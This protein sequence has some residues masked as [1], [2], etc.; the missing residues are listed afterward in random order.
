MTQPQQSISIRGAREHNLQN[1][2]LEIPRDRLV[3]ITG[4][5]GSGKSSLAFDTIFAEGQRRYLESLSAYARQFMGVME[6]P[7]VDYIDGLSPVIAI[8]QKSVSRNPRSTVGTVTEVYDFLRLL[9]ARVG[10]PHS[11]ASGAALQKQSERE[12][13]ASILNLKG[14]AAPRPSTM[15]IL[16]PVVRGRRGHYR[17]RFVRIEAQ[18][19]R[20]V[21]VD[22]KVR[23][24]KP[25]MAL[26][27][28]RT[29]DIDVV[30]DRLKLTGDITERVRQSV[31]TALQV[32]SGRLVVAIDERKDRVYSTHLYD[33]VT[34]R[35]YGEASPGLFSFNSP[36][37]ACKLCKGLGV[38][39]EFA[40]EM[41]MTHPDHTIK[42][43]I[44][45][46]LARSNH[47]GFLVKVEAMG[48]N[49]GFNLETRVCDLSDK[50]Q[51]VL[52]HGAGDESFDLAPL[53]GTPFP[54]PV[55]F[56]GLHEFIRDRLNKATSKGEERYYRKFL[57]KVECRDCQGTRLGPEPLSYRFAGE[58]IG[59]L[60]RLDVVSLLQFVQ[61]VRLSPRQERIATPIL[62]EVGERL[63]FMIDV[64]VGYLNL[65]RETRSLS[66]GESQ[67][68]RLATQIGT[69]L[70]G[71]LYVLDEPSI[72][73]HPRDNRRL[74][75]SLKQLRDIGNSVLVVEHDREM[76]ESA[77]YVVD[78]G[79]G[80]GER[81]GH[82]VSAGS[83]DELVEQ[84]NGM[85]SL[86]AEYLTGVREIGVPARRRAPQARQLVLRGATGHNL[87]GDTLI[88]P[89]GL[90]IC[91]TGV[92]GSGKSTLINQTL[93]RVLAQKLMG[94][95]SRLALPYK[96][97]EGIEHV[98]KV[99]A[100]DQK[101]IGRTPRS[102]PATY[103]G[104][105]T[106]LRDLFAGIPESLVRGYRK[107]RFSFN[108]KGGRCEE[109]T[110]AGMI[111]LEMSFLPDVFVECEACRGRRYNK[112]TLEVRYKAKS[113]ADVLHMTVDEAAA[114]F[115]HL[116]KIARKLKTLQSVGLG[117]IRL[118]QQSTTIS[119]GEAQRV[120]LSKEL[121]RPGT[122]DTLYIL[123][124]PTTGLHFEDIRYLLGVLQALVDR[125]NTVLVI[126]HNMDVIK[127]A[128]YIVDLG[129]EGGDGGGRILFAGTPEALAEEDTD[130]GVILRQVLGRV[131]AVQPALAHP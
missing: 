66:G 73:L 62:K 121:S 20:R 89:L 98:G 104:L 85:V 28:Y 97:L 115:E 128:D 81:G 30:V 58:S 71:V 56:E 84:T 24:I 78:L 43:V 61:S 72:G 122:G 120:K 101:P 49:Y 103:T 92:S 95:V 53:Y 60:V 32:G 116:P 102:N 5:S 112:E 17:E 88:L 10:T 51:H 79:P 123:D 23:V 108:V 59:D 94:A 63:S 25:G 130:T 83:P 52:L 2:S 99:I 47:G 67:R 41:V 82:V 126:E 55:H 91:V 14:P 110:G 87:R 70:T 39:Y 107:G 69:K 54:V 50:V 48:W 21:R 29:H 4:L 105:M 90:F 33:P 1:V 74:I 38:S 15:M 93:R 118:G 76:I 80:A 100:I 64:G 68:I 6:R 45:D 106:P 111:R 37:G 27:R 75:A 35:S 46:I 42:R 127:V 125:G 119:G 8:G 34:G 40:S 18:G 31:E 96:S 129:P 86:T 22:G 19:F 9:F 77:D 131:P 26:H 13:V 36:Y 44:Q 57:R 124:E 113:I 11:L 7:D 65:N 16:A 12:I 109:C 114:F 117:Y 3:V